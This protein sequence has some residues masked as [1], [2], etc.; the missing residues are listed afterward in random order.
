[1]KLRILGWE[2]GPSIRLDH[3]E[4]AYAGK[5]V[6]PSGKA[7]AQ[8]E[9]ATLDLPDPKDGAATG[10]EAVVAFDEDRVDE[11]LWLRY[12]SVR[13]GRRAEGLGARLCAFV[14]ER[15]RERGY[16]TL[17]IAVNNPFAF[18]ALYKAGFGFTGRETGL[19]ELV[20]ERPPPA[21]RSERRYR[22]GLDRFEARTLEADERQ[23][24][25]AREGVPELVTGDVE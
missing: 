16:D 7:I 8:A 18:E 5:F 25:E 13:S 9:D 2:P 21:A 1:M 23:F 3:R 4:F 24:I 10:I 6:R 11:A 17:R 14:C 22:A 19:A 20:L 12:V 15:A